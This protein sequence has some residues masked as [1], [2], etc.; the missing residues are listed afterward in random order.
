M[1]KLLLEAL[2]ELYLNKPFVYKSKHGGRTQCICTEVIIINSF[3]F[4]EETSTI[5][6]LLRE[7][8]KPKGSKKRDYQLFN[9]PQIHL[10]SENNHLYAF[11][12]CYILM[13]EDETIW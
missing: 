13:K 6:D 5:I 3:I 4:D 9:Q 8:I 12:D 1:S 7:G 10:R 11:S 2:E